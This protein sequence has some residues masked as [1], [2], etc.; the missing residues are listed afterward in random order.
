MVRR[1]L[2]VT[3]RLPGTLFSVVEG[4]RRAHYPIERNHV[5]AHVT[6]FHALPPSAEPEVRR[7]LAS[8]AQSTAA[9]PA[10]TCG[11][12]DLG[13]GTAIAIASPA[14]SA[15]HRDLSVTLHGLLGM[16][17]AGTPRFHITIQNK[18]S[19]AEARALQ[20]TL[21]GRVL[22]THFAFAGL[23]LHRLVPLAIAGGGAVAGEGGAAWEPAGNWTFRGRS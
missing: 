4:L 18:V 15:L 6:L 13:S 22:D 2:V 10:C 23:D 14:L 19:R 7:L 11:L 20:A 3:A 17:D 16:Q 1:P 5:P 8:V 21:K 9:P 12:T